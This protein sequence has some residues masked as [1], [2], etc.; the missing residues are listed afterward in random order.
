MDE[1]S[2]V[3]RERT[4]GLVAGVTVFFG[5][6]F[7]IA[8]LVVRTPVPDGDGERVR[9]LEL[10][11]AF[12]HSGLRVE[13]VGD[14]PEADF[15]LGPRSAQGFVWAHAVLGQV[16]IYVDLSVPQACPT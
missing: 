16:R 7:L 6:A 14:Q 1:A 2:G 4:R 5:L 12:A 10:N 9:G 15:G 11:L 13:P 3:V 8:G